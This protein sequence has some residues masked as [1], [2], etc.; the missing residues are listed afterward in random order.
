MAEIPSSPDRPHILSYHGR[1]G[2]LEFFLASVTI[3]IVSALAAIICSGLN[4]AF[5]F[6]SRPPSPVWLVG[7]MLGLVLVALI[8]AVL[9]SSFV[10]R[11]F[12]D[13]GK[14]GNWWFA[15]LIPIYNIHLAIG[16]LTERGTIGSNQYGEDPLPLHGS[17]DIIHRFSQNK[18]LRI[19]TTVVLIL[20]A[21]IS[22]I[23]SALQQARQ[24]QDFNQIM[25]NTLEAQSQ[26]QNQ[27]VQEQLSAAGLSQ[28]PST[29]MEDIDTTLWK[30]TEITVPG[31]SAC[32]TIAYPPQL[33]LANIVTDVTGGIET[34]FNVVASSTGYL[35]AQESVLGMETVTTGATETTTWRLYDNLDDAIKDQL[36]YMMTSGWGEPQVRELATSNGLEEREMLYGESNNPST[37]GTWTIYIQSLVSGKVLCDRR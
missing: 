6:S 24:Q 10:V 25:T 30:S 18:P 5:L 3:S 26:Q 11:R 19:L 4:F 14:S 36:N 8:P 20:L 31:V 17:D 21:S 23:D 22:G 33:T 32:Y 28:G 2:R 27:L 37:N 34:G 29:E 12:H 9:T 1:I 35:R 16:L 7:I 15:L 13:V